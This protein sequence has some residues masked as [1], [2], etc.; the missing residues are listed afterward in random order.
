MVAI[1]ISFPVP[2]F[3][4]QRRHVV[5]NVRSFYYYYY[6]GYRG[7]KGAEASVVKSFD[8]LSLS[9]DGHC[10][11]FETNLLLPFWDEEINHFTVER[12]LAAAYH[13]MRYFSWPGFYYLGCDGMV[14][15]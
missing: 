3:L 8:G 7:R 5:I 12:F 13:V 11:I 4:P 15:D 14:R 10:L 9:P 6:G 1:S 2:L